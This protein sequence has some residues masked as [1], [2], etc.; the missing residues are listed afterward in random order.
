MK[1]RSR[2]QAPPTSGREPECLGL[3]TRLAA[4][5][6]TAV[7]VFT[8][9]AEGRAQVVNL[10]ADK[11]HVFSSTD[12]E[13]FPAISLTLGDQKDV[14]FDAGP[15]RMRF[16]GAYVEG[17][18]NG[19]K[20]NSHV[21]FARIQPVGT[22]S[23]VPLGRFPADG[24]A[25]KLLHF[26]DPITGFPTGNVVGGLFA[27]HTFRLGTNYLNQL[28]NSQHGTGAFL[29]AG[30]AVTGYVGLRNSSNRY[31]GWFRVKVTNNGAGFP[32][33]LS[34]VD[35][36]GDGI[37]GAYGLGSDHLSA[38]EAAAAV[39]EP[40]SVSGGLALFAL[41]AVGVREFRR[42]RKQDAA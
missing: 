3:Q 28:V 21:G 39:P 19:G 8:M 33:S 23:D 4:Y 27:Q 34:L 15:F 9:G 1:K 11:I 18:S 29:A 38:G 36:N 22:S 42:R 24:D 13:T 40:A 7:A 30:Q 6:A 25:I 35:K 37:Y 12:G 14:W 17:S 41:G 26:G 5:S 16:N 31:Y 10:T 20:L 32:I 2:P